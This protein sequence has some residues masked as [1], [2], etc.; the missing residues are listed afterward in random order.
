[1]ADLVASVKNGTIADTSSSTSAASKKG[2]S[3][4][5]KDEFLKLLVTQLQYQDP[6][7]PSQDT[8]FISQ[9]ATFSSLEQMQNL[10]AT[11][12]NAQAFSLVG[13]TV[14]VKSTDSSGNETSKQGIVDYV[15][16]SSGKAYLSIE[17]T[18]YPIDDLETVIDETYLL[19]QTIPSVE[20]TKIKYDL[21]DPSDATVKVSMG[22]ENTV[23]TAIAVV[24]NGAVVDSSY[25]S[26]NDKG[27][28]TIKK[29]A[30]KDLT[31]GTY[32][33]TLAFN[34]AL[35]TIVSNKVKI[36]ITGVAPATVE[37]ADDTKDDATD[38]TTTGA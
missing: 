20:E 16:M 21:N 29:E 11:S 2:T 18:L 3:N 14:V 36:V 4:L 24:V 13:K 7:N 38:D 19:L 15:T 37:D 1:M 17:D 27:T 31:A 35:G 10:N 34:D 30:F 32:N 22:T 12:T 6:L 28:L 33:I 9:L 5:G 8:E 25:L 23:A 26:M